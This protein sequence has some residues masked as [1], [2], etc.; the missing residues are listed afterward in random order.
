MVG[1]RLRRLAHPTAI[2][3]SELTHEKYSCWCAG[4]SPLY[5][6]HRTHGLTNIGESIMLAISRRNL[7]AFAAACGLFALLPAA[8]LAEPAGDDKALAT[9]LRAGGHVILVR[10]GATF[11]DQADTDPL[12]P[13][14]V[15]AQRNL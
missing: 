10:H 7:A 6:S 11:A 3:P 4:I 5:P 1:T 9:A 2:F 8:A 13:D 12:N 15:A 14:N